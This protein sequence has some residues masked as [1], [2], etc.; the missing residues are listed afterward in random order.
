MT[1]LNL[2]RTAFDYLLTPGPGLSSVVQQPLSWIAWHL[3][4]KLSPQKAEFLDSPHPLFNPGFACSRRNLVEVW[5]RDPR[6][7]SDQWCALKKLRLLD[8]LAENRWLCAYTVAPLNYGAVKSDGD[9]PSLDHVIPTLRGPGKLSRSPVKICAHR[10]NKMKGQIPWALWTRFS[11]ADV[12]RE[13]VH[14]IKF[15]GSL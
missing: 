13:R 6:I 14:A 1:S 15:A 11:S 10:I 7:N 5:D 9:A 2:S 8:E 4:L 3:G 12:S